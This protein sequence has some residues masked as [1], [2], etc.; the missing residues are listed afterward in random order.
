ITGIPYGYL[1]WNI[2]FKEAG[3]TLVAKTATGNGGQYIMVIPEM[4]LVA[5]FTGGAFNSQEDKLP[6]AIMKD[7]IIPTF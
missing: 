4:K 2:P 3:K 1:W 7:V 6:F 5:V